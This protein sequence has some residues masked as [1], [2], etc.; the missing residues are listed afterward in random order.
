MPRHGH[1]KRLG[2]GLPGTF[3]LR[4]DV[5]RLAQLSH[6]ASEREEANR[7]RV[8]DV[9]CP[10]QGRRPV[11]LRDL[12]CDRPSRR[13][14]DGPTQA[15]NRGVLTGEQPDGA[16]ADR[17]LLAP[18]AV[19]RAPECGG[20]HPT[21]G[22]RLVEPHGE[23]FRRTGFVE[24][25]PGEVARGAVLGQRERIAEAEGHPRGRQRVVVPGGVADEDS[26]AGSVGMAHPQRIGRGEEPTLS[27]S[28]EERRPKSV[29]QTIGVRT[30]QRADH[31]PN[32]IPRRDV[33]DQPDGMLPQTINQ[34]RTVLGAYDM[35][36]ALERQPH[37]VQRDSEH[38]RVGLWPRGQAQRP[39][40]HRGSTV[41]SDNQLGRD[42]S[43]FTV[44][45]EG[46]P[47][48]FDAAHTRV[49]HQVDTRL[50]LDCLAQPRDQPLVFPRHALTPVGI[51]KEYRL[52]SVLGEHDEPLPR[53]AVGL[54]IGLNSQFVEH[55]HRRRMQPLARQPLGGVRI[56]LQHGDRVA[57]PGV[58]KR[59]E[60]A[61][62]AGADYGDVV[63]AGLG[64]THRIMACRGACSCIDRAAMS[65][66][67]SSASRAR[68]V[69]SHAACGDLFGNTPERRDSNTKHS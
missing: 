69:S 13:R 19:D 7:Q 31:L 2:Q 41:R 54:L 15:H 46:D 57:V 34:N 43:G 35:A 4:G 60:A 23:E 44:A 9:A 3:L 36:V 17:G 42:R 50:V 16:V 14:P 8:G 5:A 26:T 10:A 1:R 39:P 33:H 65:R 52:R 32:R 18:L 53:S 61:D 6:P 55:P 27:Q 51:G 67:L 24:S 20:L 47:V 30:R 12:P 48:V 63:T 29:R 59:A 21:V 25:L 37:I 28:L 49:H 40:H 22:E 11:G 58:S 64:A 45:G 56:R 66:P 38:L 62:R 68:V